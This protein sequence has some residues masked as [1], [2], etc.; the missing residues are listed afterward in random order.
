MSKIFGVPRGNI[1]SNMCLVF[2]IHPSN[3]NLI[4]RVRARVSVSD[5]CLVLVKVCGNS[6]NKLF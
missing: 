3:I 5:R 1:C 4:H 6:S 2:L